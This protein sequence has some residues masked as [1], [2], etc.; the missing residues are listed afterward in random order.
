LFGAPYVDR[1]FIPTLQ[2]YDLPG[3]AFRETWF[4]PTFH[5][6]AETTVRG[7][8]MYVTD[9]AAYRPVRSGLAVLTTLA[10]LYPDDFV[11]VADDDVAGSEESPFAL[12][13]L[14]GSDSLRH[15]LMGGGDAMA[16]VDGIAARPEDVY[17]ATVLLY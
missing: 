14:W 9:R 16:L 17:P 6:Y 12:D 5:K 8:Q 4:R 11:V 3:V 15:A 10:D 7:A 2:G 13:R 1:R